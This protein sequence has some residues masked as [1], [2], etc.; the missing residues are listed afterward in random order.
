MKTLFAVAV[1]TSVGLAQDAKTSTK[2][3][4][5]EIITGTLHVIW[6]LQNSPQSYDVLAP[7]KRGLW[8]NLHSDD[9]SVTSFL[10]TLRFREDDGDL[11]TIT[12]VVTNN[13][14]TPGSWGYWV[15]NPEQC[16]F[17]VGWPSEIT[18]S[19]TEQRGHKPVIIRLSGNQPVSTQRNVQV[20]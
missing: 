20:R 18:Y 6:T 2:F 11:R 16:I 19:V 3:Y 1:L 13:A 10:V 14:N 15:S 4:G 7:G 12:R 17:W 5:Q 9:S 8:I